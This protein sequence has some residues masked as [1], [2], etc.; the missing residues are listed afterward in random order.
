LPR[1]DQAAAERP[2]YRRISTRMWGDEKFRRLSKPKPNGQSLW[3][4]LL[5]GPQT[6]TIPGLF[7]MGP[8]GLAELLDWPLGGFRKAWG[9]LE[10]LGM[11]RADWTSRLVWIPNAIRHNPPESPNVIRGWRATLAD[12]PECSLKAEAIAELRSECQAFGEGFAKAFDEALAA[13]RR[14]P[15]PNQEQEQEQEQERKGSRVKASPNPSKPEQ[16]HEGQR[17]RFDAFMSVFPRKDGVGAA[18]KQ[19]QLMQPDEAFSAQITAGAR[20]YAA[21]KAVQR[22]I[23]DGDE[24]FVRMAKNWLA[25][26]GWQDKPAAAD[27]SAQ[28]IVSGCPHTPRCVGDQSACTARYLEEMRQPAASAGGSVA[29]AS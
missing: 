10:Q 4:F 15:S 13:P 2:R 5:T 26:E 12:M 3:Q 20:G 11:V 29:R 17:A 1:D 6:K 19:W 8:A 7:S 21:S 18:W 16:E 27:S 25:D 24:R 14:K 9:E 28:R 23:A 22:W